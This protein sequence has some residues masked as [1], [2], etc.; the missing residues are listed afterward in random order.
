MENKQE[1]IDKFCE[2]TFLEKLCTVLQI[3]VEIRDSCVVRA[4][5]EPFISK[6]KQQIIINESI[7]IIEKFIKLVD[8]ETEVPISSLEEE[9]C[10]DKMNICDLLCLGMELLDHLEEDL[11]DYFK[12]IWV[13]KEHL[14]SVQKKI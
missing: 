8:E 12:V 3:F 13:L 9:K 7:D 1:I 10:Y 6:I 11:Y 14:T 2:N 5:R 4:E